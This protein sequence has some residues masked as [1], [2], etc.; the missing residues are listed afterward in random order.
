MNENGA[1]DHLLKRHKALESRCV[2]QYPKWT[3]VDFVA[4]EI[5]LKP[6]E[7]PQPATSIPRT[8]GDAP[9][10]G[11]DALPPRDTKEAW[12]RWA[13]HYSN[14]VAQLSAETTRLR[15]DLDAEREAHKVTAVALDTTT[16]ERNHAFS[17]SLEYASRLAAEREA[18]ARDQLNASDLA[19]Q[20]E[21]ITLDHHKLR[22]H[23][24]SYL[25]C[26]VPTCKTNREALA[27]HDARR[28]EG[29]EA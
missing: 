11:A 12:E 20:L 22:G 19:I 7:A 23:S 10:A 24:G 27:A 28:R 17:T 1:R 14:Q 2:E 13:N 8:I 16:K 6:N 15:A 18:H 26:S 29:G 4:L 3:T 9:E 25:A 5:L 21:N